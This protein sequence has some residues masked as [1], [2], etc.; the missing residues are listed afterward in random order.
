MAHG[1]LYSFGWVGGWVFF[2]GGGVRGKARCT[3]GGV[4]GEGFGGRWVWGGFF[5]GVGKVGG[6]LRQLRVGMGRPG[7]RGCWEGTG[8]GVGGAKTSS[9]ASSANLPPFAQTL[10]GRGATKQPAPQN[11]PTPNARPRLL[12]Q[13]LSACSPTALPS[14]SVVIT[15]QPLAL[16][17]TSRAY[18]AV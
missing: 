14:L 11:P 13:T 10:L 5:R 18:L 3:A 16:S 2:G 7:L 1:T 4:G 15:H 9:A 6:T 12:T 17:G 8:A